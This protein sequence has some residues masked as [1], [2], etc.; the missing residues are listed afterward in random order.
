MED[1]KSS[2]FLLAQGLT[3]VQ[4]NLLMLVSMYDPLFNPA[5]GIRNK[6]DAMQF[7]INATMKHNGCHESSGI[8]YDEAE[9]LFNFICEHV[10]F[11]EESTKQV[12][13]QI[14][15]ILEVIFGGNPYDL[16]SQLSK[17]KVENCS[18]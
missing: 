13:G 18:E 14:L 6:A 7:A 10:E 8:D 12:L 4:Y 15:P 11:P 3:W 2:S 9:K 1:E 5:R 16:T 17:L